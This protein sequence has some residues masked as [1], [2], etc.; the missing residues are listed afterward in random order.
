MNQHM[1]Y[2]VAK[3]HKQLPNIW[4]RG[5]I[6]GKTFIVTT[7]PSSDHAISNP[8]KFMYSLEGLDKEEY[9]T[10]EE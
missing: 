1:K 5:E 6:K 2:K 4:I 10:K 7:L 3:A 9:F 8:T